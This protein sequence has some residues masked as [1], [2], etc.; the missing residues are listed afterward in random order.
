MQLL[1]TKDDRLLYISLKLL[2]SILESKN[3]SAEIKEK[4]DLINEYS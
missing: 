3:I 2:E 4:Y 1:T